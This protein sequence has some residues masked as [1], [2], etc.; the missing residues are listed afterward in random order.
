MTLNNG[1]T[2]ILIGV[3]LYAFVLIPLTGIIIYFEDVELM[4][5]FYLA[6]LV[7]VIVFVIEF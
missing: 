6:N 7:V 1:E 3:L 5:L 2:L 4:P